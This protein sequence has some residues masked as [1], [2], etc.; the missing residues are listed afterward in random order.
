MV[1][2][3]MFCLLILVSEQLMQLGSR[4]PFI[5]KI[6]EFL[7]PKPGVKDETWTFLEIR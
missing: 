7:C 5:S 2:D 4:M 6:K 3:I 1:L